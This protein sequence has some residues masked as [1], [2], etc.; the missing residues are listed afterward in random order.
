MFNP[1]GWAESSGE[2]R[3]IGETSRAFPWIFE[4]RP[5]EGQEWCPDLR[6][7]VRDRKGVFLFGPQSS[8]VALER[9][10][11][12]G[13]K[14]QSRGEMSQL[15]QRGHISQAVKPSEISRAEA[16]AVILSISPA[17]GSCE[18]VSRTTSA[19][20]YHHLRSSHKLG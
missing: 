20:L 4:S 7:P 11:R 9:R 5:S 10:G 6:E 2:D 18:A 13:T 17:G 8:G 15:N 16:S 12:P 1:D 3:W 19:D 14:G